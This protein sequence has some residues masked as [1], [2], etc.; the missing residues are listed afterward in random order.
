MN[1]QLA[2]GSLVLVTLAAF[3]PAVPAQNQA[4][5]GFEAGPE[6]WSLN[7]WDTVTPTGGNPDARLHWDN[8]I[9]TFGMSARTESHK[10]FIGDYTQKGPVTLAIDFQVNFIQLFG[11]VSRDLAVI[12]YDDDGFA[13]APPAAVWTLLGTLDGNGMPWTTFQANVT[14]VLSDTLP[15]G[16]QGYGDYDPK[17]FEPILPP[18]RTWSNVLQGIDRIEFTTFVPGWFFLSTFFDLSIDNV[19]IEPLATAWTD[20]RHALAGVAGDPEL[21]GE[22]TLEV[23]SANSVDLSNAAPSAPAGLFVGT[24][25]AFAPFKGGTLVP[26]FIVP[27]IVVVTGAGGELPIG[28]VMPAGVPAGTE[29][30]LQWAIQDAAAMKGVA[31]SNAIKGLV[32]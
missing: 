2:T 26:A 22:G 31:L 15:A 5:V 13:G 1:L 12:L 11:P 30:W 18:G 14:D 24:S 8:F 9:D 16:W 20:E 10:A 21:V 19:S 25:A 23:G 6:G 7:G 17:T 27:P 3:A 29:L 28:F 32:P 4:H